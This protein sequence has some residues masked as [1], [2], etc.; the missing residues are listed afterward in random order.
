MHTSS[1]SLC[2]SNWYCKYAQYAVETSCAIVFDYWMALWKQNCRNERLV[3]IFVWLIKI[4]A[5]QTSVCH[6]RLAYKSL[7]ENRCSPH[8]KIASN[9]FCKWR[10][11]NGTALVLICIVFS[12]ILKVPSFLWKLHSFLFDTR[13]EG[14]QHWDVVAVSE[15]DRIIFACHSERACTAVTLID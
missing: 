6:D 11:S 5:L 13:R 10:Y 2:A 3:T 14:G 15:S 4:A 1:T 7:L 12:L 9:H 8:L